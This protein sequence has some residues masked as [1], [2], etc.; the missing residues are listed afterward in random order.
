MTY[1]GLSRIEDEDM[2]DYL[3]RMRK[4]VRAVFL[5]AAM[6]G[7]FTLGASCSWLESNSGAAKLTVQYATIKVIDHD[8]AK[9][10]RVM[11]IAK[12][13]QRIAESDTHLTVDRL[14]DAIVDHIDFDA[15]DTADKLLVT[16][17]LNELSRE[18][19]AR[20]P[21]DNIAELKLTVDHIAGWVVSAAAMVR[22]APGD[23]K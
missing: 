21:E 11:A 15:L 1:D 7:G 12:E 3:N 4:S 23:G 9:A 14:M 22:V 13:V 20:I 5:A 16:A 10:R 8:P 19:K 6:L 2:S 18:L 17:L